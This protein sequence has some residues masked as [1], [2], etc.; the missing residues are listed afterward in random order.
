MV[1]GGHASLVPQVRPSF[2]LTWAAMIRSH[3]L[4]PPLPNLGRFGYFR[5]PAPPIF[6]ARPPATAI[7]LNQGTGF[8]SL[9]R[10]HPARGPN[11]L[12]ENLCS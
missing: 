9:P 1:G 3:Q 10:P 8:V 11:P 2:G 12:S 4:N 5:F 7:H 6:L